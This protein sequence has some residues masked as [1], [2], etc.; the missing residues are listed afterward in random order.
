MFVHFA[1]RRSK[2]SFLAFETLPG[3]LV[4][5]QWQNVDSYSM[6]YV[7]EGYWQQM[8]CLP[9]ATDCRVHGRVSVSWVCFISSKSWQLYLTT[10]MHWM[11]WVSKDT[12]AEGCSWVM[13]ISLRNYSTTLLSRRRLTNALVPRYHCHHLSFY[14]SKLLYPC[15]SYKTY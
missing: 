9:W 1:C 10:E 7:W 12:V 6:L 3:H 8:G 4:D 15:N 2:T 13:W 14:A 11:P 5:W